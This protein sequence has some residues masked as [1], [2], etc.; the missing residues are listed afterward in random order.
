MTLT[1]DVDRLGALADW[2]ARPDNPFF[3]RTQVNR[4][5]YHLMGRGIVEPNDDFRASNPQI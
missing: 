2:V 5:W 4:V 3:A 1:G